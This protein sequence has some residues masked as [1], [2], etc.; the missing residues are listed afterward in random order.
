[1][2]VLEAAPAR[3]ELQ[4]DRPVMGASSFCSGGVPAAGALDGEDTVATEF[5]LIRGTRA[6]A[7][8]ACSDDGEAPLWRASW[9]V[10]MA[11]ELR[12]YVR[13]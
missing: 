6:I 5:A 8:N 13:L 4:F 1:M 7:L 2:C 3:F 10:L 12:I 9:N 11:G